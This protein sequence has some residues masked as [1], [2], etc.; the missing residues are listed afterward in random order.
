MRVSHPRR[1]QFR[2]LRHAGARAIQAAI[3]LAGAL[4]LAVT[5]EATFAFV[6]LLLSVGLSLD[7]AR[8]FRLAGRS[9][10]GAESETKVRRALEP[11]TRDGWHVA[12]AVDWPAAGDLDHVVRSP[13]GIGFV[14]ETKTLRYT[15]AHRVRTA[16]AAH[17]LGR[18][19]RRYPLDVRP[20]ICVARA[21]RIERFEQGVLVVSVDRLVPA[22]V[23]AAGTAQN[24]SAGTNPPDGSS[25][26]ASPR[27]PISP[28][29]SGSSPRLRPARVRA[30]ARRE[31]QG[32]DAVRRSACSTM[33]ATSTRESAPSLAKMLRMWVST[34]LGL[35]NSSSAI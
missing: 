34:V 2:R 19:R 1:Q 16:D 9:A 24:S 10:V 11:L 14:I 26:N 3:A 8:A 28:G 30:K 21:R 33:R 20:V 7:G 32:V 18:R 23:R 17:W 31:G 4:T 27:S 35:R 6:A 5:G 22:L 12:H 15:R 25:P 29:R 13:F